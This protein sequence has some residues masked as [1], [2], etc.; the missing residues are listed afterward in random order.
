MQWEAK[1][2]LIWRKIEQC[3]YCEDEGRLYI[4]PG[5][6][7]LGAC[8]HILVRIVFYHDYTTPA[9]GKKWVESKQ[10]E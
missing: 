3:L 9:N 2:G 4:I 7:T 8:F 6:S 1:K 5:C 10:W